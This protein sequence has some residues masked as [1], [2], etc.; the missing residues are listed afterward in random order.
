MTN[1]KFTVNCET[2][3]EGKTFDTND[4][5]IA[6]NVFE[7]YAMEAREYQLSEYEVVLIDNRTGEVYRHVNYCSRRPTEEELA[8]LD[9]SENSNPIENLLSDS[10]AADIEQCLE[11]MSADE[12]A[13]L[14]EI[15]L[16]IFNE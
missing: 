13:E 15:L 11:E 16:D 8:M 2:N 7:D 6:N 4:F 9:E 14:A 3:Y 12:F 10:L 1:F 5:Q